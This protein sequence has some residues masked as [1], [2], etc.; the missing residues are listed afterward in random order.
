MTTL[1]TTASMTMASDVQKLPGSAG[2]RD[3]VFAEHFGPNGSCVT[4]PA[5]Q[6]HSRNDSGS[7]VSWILIKLDAAVCPHTAHL[8][9]DDGGVDDEISLKKRIQR[10]WLWLC[11]KFKVSK[12]VLRQIGAMLHRRSWK[13]LCGGGGGGGG[14]GSSVGILYLFDLF[15]YVASQCSSH[16]WLKCFKKIS[17]K[18]KC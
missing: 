7:R 8:G 12:T 1:M 5:G 2:L 6:S 15:I 10:L 4:W 16:H 3:H 13:K 14:G 17:S 11:C 9:F 18:T